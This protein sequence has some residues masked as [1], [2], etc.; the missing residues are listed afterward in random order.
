V[1]ERAMPVY[2]GIFD[3]PNVLNAKFRGEVKAKGYEGWIELQNVQFANARTATG[4]SGLQ[5]VG[6]ASQE[7]NISKFQDAVSALLFME[8]YEGKGR[9]IVIAFVKDDKAYQTFML[10]NAMISSYNIG[11][12]VGSD[13]SGQS[14]P[15]ESLT[16]KFT[17][18]SYEMSP[19]SPDIT[20]Q[21]KIRL[22]Q[23][24]IRG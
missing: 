15:M 13:D 4:L 2:M 5:E 17:N 1:T 7:I 12:T 23:L 10:Q 19:K 21:Q 16:L 3:K 20:H 14:R 8:A 24:G 6:P 18:I 11:G 22:Q 9:L